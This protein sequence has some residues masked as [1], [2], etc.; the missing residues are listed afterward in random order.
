MEGFE[1]GVWL[2]FSHIGK[3][4]GPEAGTLHGQ[5]LSAPFLLPLLGLHLEIGHLQP[6]RRGLPK[7]LPGGHIIFPKLNPFWMTFCKI[8]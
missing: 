7:P 8:Q 2:H 3:L 6:S 4:N 1:T 5:W